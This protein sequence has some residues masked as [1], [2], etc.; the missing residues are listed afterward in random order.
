MSK[1]KLFLWIFYCISEMCMKGRTFLKERWVSYHHYF[2]NYCIRKT[3]LLKTCC[4]RTPFG[5]QRV[6]EFQTLLK[7]TT[8]HYEPTFWEIRGKLSWKKS[9]LVISEILRLF[10]NT[11]TADDKYFRRNMHSFPQQFQTLL[12]QK[13]KTFCG[14]FIGFLK[15][16]RK[17]EYF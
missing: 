11:L 6:T 4:L 3:R 15:C 12:C 10:F 5:N 14:F 9:A 7:S 17:V 2:R 1:R 16:A 13:G 8:H